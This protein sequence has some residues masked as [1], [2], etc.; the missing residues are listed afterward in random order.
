MSKSVYVHVFHDLE[1]L[2]Y[3]LRCEIERLL[4]FA[5]RMNKVYFYCYCF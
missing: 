2:G 3:V 1:L 5:A 4:K